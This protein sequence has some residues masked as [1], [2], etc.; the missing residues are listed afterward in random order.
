MRVF[1]GKDADNQTILASAAP[2]A[3]AKPFPHQFQMQDQNERS[4]AKT[5][6]GQI[7]TH[8]NKRRVENKRASSSVFVFRRPCTL[9]GAGIAHIAQ[10]EALGDGGVRDA[11]GT[12]LSGGGVLASGCAGVRRA[13]GSGCEAQEKYPRPACEAGF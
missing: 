1:A 13:G 9:G 4:F 5:G 8:G 10:P 3:Q 11:G 2:G 6:S 12:R 7:L